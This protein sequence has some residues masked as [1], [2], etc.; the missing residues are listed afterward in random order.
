[1]AI[2]TSNIPWPHTQ[3]AVP[4]TL[5]I[6]EWQIPT[7]NAGP[8]G[9]NVDSTGRVWFTENQTG[10]LGMLDPA[11][12]NIYEWN[13]P[14]Q[15]PGSFVNSRNIFTSPYITYQSTSFRAYFAE[16]TKDKI[17]YLDTTAPT[18]T[19]TTTVTSTTTIITSTTTTNTANY[20]TEWQL[21]TG[22]KPVSIFV[23]DQQPANIWFTE[24]GRDAIG[25]LVGGS[26]TNAQFIEWEL[27]GGSPGGTC[28]A[29]CVWGLYV[30][31]AGSDHYVWFTERTGGSADAGLVGRLQLS[32][33]LLTTW[34]LSTLN[35]GMY[36]PR[37]IAVDSAGNAYFSNYLGNRISVLGNSGTYKEYGIATAAAEPVAVTTD[38]TRNLLWFLEYTG[39]NIAYLNSSAPGNTL[40]L[41]ASQCVIPSTVTVT[42]AITS[43]RVIYTATTNLN[44]NV[45]PCSGGAYETGAVS[46]TT[47]STSL[48]LP[49]VVNIN[50]S[51]HPLGGA[52]ALANGISE[53]GLPSAN[54]RPYGVTLDSNGDLWLTES[55]YSANRIAEVPFAADFNIQL[56]SPAQ[57]AVP[58]GGEYAFL[59]NV[60][61]VSGSQSQVS[62][63]VNAPSGLNANFI[64]SIGT[65]PFQ[66]VLTI[67]TTVSAP[68]STYSMTITGTSS[69]ATHSVNIALTVLSISAV[70]STVS[71]I[72]SQSSSQSSVTGTVSTVILTTT[73]YSIGQAG[74]TPTS[75]YVQVWSNST[76]SALQF[77]SSRRLL[78]FTATGPPGTIGQ[79]KVVI[80][81]TLLDGS[82]TVIIDDG[83]TPLLSLRVTSNSTDYTIDFTYPHSTHAITVGGQN[84]IPEFPTSLPAL[85][86]PL[87][88]ITLGVRARRKARVSKTIREIKHPT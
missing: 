15:L 64:P 65:P 44:P 37:D 46:M 73:I 50:P 71:S 78:N 69:S 68:P 83:R 85:A 33:N 26:T 21:L 48:A 49:R 70:S 32:N 80:A 60:N 74:G 29:L 47:A 16:Y 39:N 9:I 30:Q 25:E 12:N 20:L 24:S 87:L 86:I 55:D 31:K 66:S 81:E 2:L 88:F 84:S 72:S 27:P 28:G 58:Q 23:D 3:A 1:M 40:S 61:A 56:T 36:Q 77:D 10:R 76:I 82:P 67:T 5:N 19:V 6:N 14:G 22:S 63:S 45:T 13:I 17:A 4:S 51:T 57:V 41:S 34:D 54:S 11:A 8:A 42:T 79:T 35:N 38:P 53:Y 7:G 59:I 18:P 43:S 75:T 62:L 52:Q